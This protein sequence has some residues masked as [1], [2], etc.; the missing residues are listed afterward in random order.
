[1]SDPVHLK[2]FHMEKVQH[3]ATSFKPALENKLE[4]SDICMRDNLI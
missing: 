1:M 4:P 3:L 2:Q